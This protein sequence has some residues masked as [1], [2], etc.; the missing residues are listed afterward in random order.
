MKLDFWM[1]VNQYWNEKVDAQLPFLT[2]GVGML[3][4]FTKSG[5]RS[6]P[7]WLFTKPFD[8][9]HPR[10]SRYRYHVDVFTEIADCLQPSTDQEEC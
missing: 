4:Y 3:N 7:D 10:L 5:D 2:G 1:R 6:P 9:T 8:Y